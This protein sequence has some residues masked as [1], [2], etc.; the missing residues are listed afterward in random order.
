M[1]KW[2]GSEGDL[3]VFKIKFRH[4]GSRPP[5]VSANLH[6]QTSTRSFPHMCAE[7]DGILDD[8]SSTSGPIKE[9]HRPGTH[10]VQFKKHWS[11]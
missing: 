10:V 6:L 4:M 11:S 2:L 9:P 1:D 8:G 3:M 5:T 7:S